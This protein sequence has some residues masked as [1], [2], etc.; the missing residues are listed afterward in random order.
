M[1]FDWPTFLTLVVVATLVVFGIGKLNE[2][3][4]AQ[5]EA[6]VASQPTQDLYR[7]WSDCPSTYPAF[8]LDENGYF[9]GEGV[10]FETSGI[11]G[12]LREELVRDGR[13]NMLAMEF[14]EPQYYE[15]RDMPLLTYMD[16][17]NPYYTKCYT[18]Q[19]LATAFGQE[20]M[21]STFGDYD[22]LAQHAPEFLSVTLNPEVQPEYRLAIM[23]RTFDYRYLDCFKSFGV[24][25]PQQYM[26]DGY[27]LCFNPDS[28]T[29]AFAADEFALSQVEVR[30]NQ[31]VTVYNVYEITSEYPY[32]NTSVW[33]IVGEEQECWEVGSIFAPLE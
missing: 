16:P 19:D 33:Q 4:A 18:R 2:L 14:L 13:C 1:K 9:L 22:P 30:V 27:N 15:V 20:N 28:I 29:A 26:V 31:T 17:E 24:N 23:L 3:S 8:K 11:L 32:N 6:S 10:I 25:T 5:S 7:N 21:H 12:F